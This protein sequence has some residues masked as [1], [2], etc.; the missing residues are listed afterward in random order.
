[1]NEENSGQAREFGGGRGTAAQV[2]LLR[3]LHEEGKL[4][5]LRVD[6]PDPATGTARQYVVEYGQGEV[7][8]LGRNLDAWAGGFEAGLEAR[9]PRKPTRP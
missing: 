8:L 5:Y 3:R 1:M 6:P 9:K 4:V 7:R 2:A